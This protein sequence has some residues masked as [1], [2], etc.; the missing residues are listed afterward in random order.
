MLN[1]NAKSVAAR[2]SDAIVAIEAAGLDIVQADIP[3]RASVIAAFKQHGADID[4]VV[5][6]G[7][8]GTLNAVLQG[9]VGSNLP[10][11]ILPLGTANDLAKT[12]GVPTDLEQAC[13]VIA[14]GHTR[15]IDVGR[16]NDVYYFNEASIGMSVALCRS[17][18]KESKSKYGIFALLLHAFQ[19][20]FAM[21]RFRALITLPSGEIIAKRTAQLTFGNG[22]NFGAFVA[23]ED[24]A[25]DDREL[26]LYS[27]EFKRW[28]DY[29][30]AIAALLHRR[31]DDIRSVFT[32][33]GRRF[34]VRT[35]K[36]KHI[37]A[38]GEIIAWTPATFSV[39][40]RAVEV[41]VPAPSPAAED[42]NREVS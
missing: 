20:I 21:R 6:G 8:D 26:D 23:T 39:V 19:I 38:D 4:L 18:T 41:F 27:V 13:D 7:G 34:E 15:R 37:E 12:L 9:L 29:F 3:T 40:P 14:A 36:R 1:D 24:A 30:E 22:Q 25:I 5:A 16:V 17:L 32:L 11:G 35:A 31:Y 28:N 42:G 2:S 10:I 33:H